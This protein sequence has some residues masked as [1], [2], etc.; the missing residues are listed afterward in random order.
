MRFLFGFFVALIVVA[1]GVGGAIYLNPQLSDRLQA[2]TQDPSAPRATTPSAPPLR[3]TLTQAQGGAA[4][5][6]APAAPAAPAPPQPKIVA[7]ENF[8]DWLYTCIERPDNAGTLCA[9]SQQIALAETKQVVFLWRISQDGKGG[10]ASVWQ[11]MTDVMVNRG[12]TIEAGTPKP[13]VVPFEFCTSRGCQAGAT[14]DPGL[15]DVLA[16]TE[17][18]AAKVTVINGREVTINISVKGLA[19][20]LAKLQAK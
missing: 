4:P 8:D 17:Q 16:K 18:A 11:T 1:L 5:Q 2:A 10:F 7:N 12:L 13:M 6:G 9:I 20:A 14:V 3:P 15:L 19:A